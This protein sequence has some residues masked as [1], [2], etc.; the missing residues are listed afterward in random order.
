[1]YLLGALKNGKDIPS[2]NEFDKHLDFVY[3]HKRGHDL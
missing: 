3:F 2:F 1:M